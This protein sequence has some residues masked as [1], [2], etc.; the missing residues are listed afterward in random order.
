MNIHYTLDVSLFSVFLIITFGAI[1]GS[2]STFLGYRLFNT[3][4]DIKLTGIRS[5]C[6]NCKHKL[7]ITDLIPIISFLCLN[8]KCRY[9]KKTIPVWHFI[10]EIMM[11][12]SF[13]A[14]LFYFKGININSVLM[15]ML[16]FCLITQSIIDYRTMMSSDIL[17]LIEFF[18]VFFLAK[19]LNIK[20][21]SIIIT[22]FVVFFTFLLIAILMKKILKKDCL[23][24]GDIKLFTILAP[25]FSIEK[26][27]LF[28]GLCGAFGI[29]FHIL[30]II[31]K[32]KIR[33]IHN[34][35]SFFSEKKHEPFC[36]IP[37]IFFAFLLAFYF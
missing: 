10:A 36:F 11:I 19:N 31:I 7:S 33:H 9:C 6:C 14:S 12:L 27:T 4:K 15:C 29:A 20:T 28:F 17:H 1:F 22:W 24:F 35:L 26:I 16:C 37:S 23:G 18:L 32:Y 3:D 25:L 13:L 8:G 34:K 5:I 21:C 2:F 30:Q